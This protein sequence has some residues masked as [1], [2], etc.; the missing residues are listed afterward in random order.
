MSAAVGAVGPY[1]PSSDT[2]YYAAQ[3]PDDINRYYAGLRLGYIGFDVPPERFAGV[4]IIETGLPGFNPWKVA[5]G[6][7]PLIAMDSIE[8]HNALMSDD[9]SVNGPVLHR[10]RDLL[11]EGCM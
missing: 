4:S 6:A 3:G 7:M 8:H 1:H 11:R 10:V 5:T 2:I 9:E